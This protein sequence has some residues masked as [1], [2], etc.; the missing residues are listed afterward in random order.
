LDLQKLDDA[1]YGG[2]FNQKME[3]R[4]MGSK[5]TNNFTNNAWE[6]EEIREYGIEFS[7]ETF[8]GFAVRH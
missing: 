4:D 5:V 1:L 3:M 2:K 6:C 8:F 7:T